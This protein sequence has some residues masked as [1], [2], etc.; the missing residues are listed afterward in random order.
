MTMEPWERGQGK[1]R[2]PRLF[3]G[4]GSGEKVLENLEKTTGST[5][6][7]SKAPTKRAEIPIGKAQERSGQAR[8]FERRNRNLNTQ[9]PVSDAN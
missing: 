7:T 3:F 6:S 1:K 4:H 8:E 9:R 2:V 5:E